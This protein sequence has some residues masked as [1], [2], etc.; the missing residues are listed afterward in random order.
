M[1]LDRAE[2][3]DPYFKYCRNLLITSWEIRYL[4]KEFGLHL[5]FLDWIQSTVWLPADKEGKKKSLCS[6]SLFLCRNKEVSNRL[7]C[8]NLGGT[9][10]DYVYRVHSDPEIYEYTIFSECFV[11]LAMIFAFIDILTF[12]SKDYKRLFK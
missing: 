4:Q 7:L 11:H 2:L 8:T 12:E 9:V 1:G 10:S 5:S 6:H 3:H